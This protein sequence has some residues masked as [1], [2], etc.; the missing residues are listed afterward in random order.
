MVTDSKFC[1]EVHMEIHAVRRIANYKPN[2]MEVNISKMVI[3]HFPDCEE[4]KEAGL[5]QK[6]APQAK[7]NDGFITKLFGGKS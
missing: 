7:S 1:E 2:P 5:K 6:Y 3:D 4:C